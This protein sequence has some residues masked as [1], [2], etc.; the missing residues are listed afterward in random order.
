MKTGNFWFGLKRGVLVVVCLV[1]AMYGLSALSGSSV[2]GSG[3]ESVVDGFVCGPD[4]W[5]EFCEVGVACLDGGSFVGGA[6]VCSAPEGVA[7]ASLDLVAYAASVCSGRAHSHGG[8]GCHTHSGPGCGAVNKTSY[9]DWGGGTNSGWHRVYP[10][11]PRCPPPTTVAPSCSGRAHSHNGGGCHTHSGPGCGAVNKT[12]YWDWGGGTNSGWHRVYPNDPRCPPPTTVAPSCSGRAHSHNGGG[13]HTHSGPGC[14]AVNPTSYWDWGGGYGNGWHKVYPN[15][16]R[17]PPPTTT[18]STTTTTTTTSTSTTTT[19]ARAPSKPMPPQSRTPTPPLPPAVPPPYGRGVR[20]VPVPV[21]SCS[22]NDTVSASWGQYSGASQYQLH[23]RGRFVDAD[24]PN[25]PKASSNI[26][27]VSASSKRSETLQ[28]RA[29]FM[30]DARLRAKANGAWTAFTGWSPTAKCVVENSPVWVTRG[31]YDG[32]MRSAANALTVSTKHSCS[33]LSVKK[34]AAIMIAI[35]VQEVTRDATK[36][37]S[38]MALSVNEVNR[39]NRFYYL[40]GTKGY[41]AA[42]WYPGVGLWQ[43]DWMGLSAAKVDVTGLNHGLRAD[44]ANN[45]GFEA[46]KMLA[47]MFC[48]GSLWAKN[49]RSNYWIGQTWAACTSGAC[50]TRFNNIYKG[51]T[52]PLK[53]HIVE[54][55][56][57]NDGG[58]QTRRCRW[59][60]N[61]EASRNGANGDNMT[62][63]LFDMDRREGYT[64]QKGTNPRV[65]PSPSS[66]KLTVHPFIAFTSDAFDSE[67]TEK[68]ESSRFAVWPKMW[69]SSTATF[70]WPTKVVQPGAGA[71]GET[72]KTIF[73]AAPTDVE[74]RIATPAP[75]VG[76]IVGGRVEGWFD[77]TVDGKSLE[78][79]DCSG[80]GFGNRNC[81]WTNLTTGVVT[82]DTS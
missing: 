79:Y 68:I 10:N 8:S 22:A 32:I 41:R 30:Y 16:P 11:D 13:C 65:S 69:P 56:N 70:R 14:G 9:W 55:W 24:H 15:D 18:S 26:F 38:P 3:S 62:C 77:N 1:V 57:D 67:N 19:I 48:R 71:S 46:A 43:L 28:G 27:Q 82:R 47:W 60:G 25:P 73:R 81:Y 54:G 78:M 20:V 37:A 74:V 31:A 80:F 53:I 63:Y 61:F 40:Q 49:Q 51:E 72:H 59:Y 36:P 33:G 45:G 7:S 23:I 5:V 44:T 17:C 2:S 35:S 52:A 12:S 64:P 50:K 4:R 21:V 29:D 6:R 39:T 34:L 76:T 58:V 42:Y 75:S 66:T